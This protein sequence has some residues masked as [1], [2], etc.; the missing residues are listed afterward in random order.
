M[1]RST[2][3]ST[4]STAAP[5]NILAWLFILTIVSCGGEDVSPYNLWD[6]RAGMSF[7]QL[8]SIAVHDQKER[9]SCVPTYG[10]YK[11]CWITVHAVPGRMS[12]IID[13]T[14]HVAIVGYHPDLP[15]LSKDLT[16]GASLVIEAH[17]LEKRWNYVTPAKSETDPVTLDKKQVWVSE[18]G[19]WTAKIDWSGSGF[20]AQLTTTDERRA[21]AY[22]RLASEAQADSIIRES[23]RSLAEVAAGGDDGLIA[24]VESELKRLAS[25]QDLHRQQA[26]RYAADLAQLHFIPKAEIE[27]DIKGASPSGWWATGSHEKLPGR[28][29]VL[30]VGAAP[31][32]SAT[33]GV[34]LGG[35]P[36]TPEC[37][38]PTL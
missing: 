35:T 26:R 14:D 34:R 24:V 33:A 32:G 11:A 29:C 20:P 17:E 19:L 23:R 37:G 7:E 5:R 21:R 10:S 13:S 38:R 25:A 3:R 16:V 30:W 22:R 28:S 18:D 36:G 12:A 15:A 8:D 2:A 6:M 9:Y 4:G 1:K 27:L 31:S